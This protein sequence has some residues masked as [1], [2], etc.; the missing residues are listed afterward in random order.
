MCRRDGSA[1]VFAEY[2]AKRKAHSPTKLMDTSS[3]LSCVDVMDA[4]IAAVSGAIYIACQRS[5][6]EQETDLSMRSS[7]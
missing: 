6:Y 5:F 7:P 1:L 4:Y 3:L 2:D